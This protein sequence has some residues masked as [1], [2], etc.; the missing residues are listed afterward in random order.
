MS[1]SVE[2]EPTHGITGDLAVVAE[3][4][5]RASVPVG[6]L[7][8][9]GVVMYTNESFAR[10]CGRPAGELVG[11]VLANS[12]VADD[13]VGLHSVLAMLRDD[14]AD[15][16]QGPAAD[17]R[18]VGAD[19]RVRA[20]RLNLGLLTGELATVLSDADNRRRSGLV[21]CIA[22]DRSEERRSE[23]GN[24]RARVAEAVSAMTDP[25]TGLLNARGIE[26]TL[27]S[28]S[29]RAGRNNA[30]FALINCVLGAASDGVGRSSGG[31]DPTGDETLLMAC[32][33]RIRQRL[34]P[35]DT[36]ARSDDS[37]LVVAEDLGDEQDAV[38]VT[39]RVLSTVI[40]PV[41]TGN[42][43]VTV[44]MHAGTVVADGST[45]VHKL[46]PAAEVAARAVQSGGFELV[47][48]RR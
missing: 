20:T 14:S 10:A 43:P 5:D 35:S 40:E 13:R 12:V 46:V 23:R 21:M 33:E 16:L 31:D 48:M 44:Q 26:L 11:A 22:T 47:D 36:V 45:P 27:E 42:G 19:G 37:I 15:P 7:G 9:D 28:A 18:F 32:V 39:Y 17:L 3:V 34:R 4:L 38:G 24:R 6:L 1:N 30:A 25:A 41:P 8:L 2:E 29:R